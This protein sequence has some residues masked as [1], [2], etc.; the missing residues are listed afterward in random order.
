MDK[1]IYDIGNEIKT[2]QPI[3]MIGE[4][5]YK[6]YIKLFNKLEEFKEVKSDNKNIMEGEILAMF[7]RTQAN[8]SDLYST[9]IKNG[10]GGTI[11]DFGPFIKRVDEFE[12]E[13]EA[14]IKACNKQIEENGI[15]IN[16]DID[17]AEQVRQSRE[18][19]TKKEG[20]DQYRI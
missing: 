3:K 8:A 15:D 16:Y 13:I 14:V 1:T 4:M 2:K 20:F 9:Y 5:I 11:N 19:I 6:S 17:I 18:F 7:N 10:A 12:E